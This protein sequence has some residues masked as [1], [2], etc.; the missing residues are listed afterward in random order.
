MVNVGS[1]KRQIRHKKLWLVRV[2]SHNDSN[3]KSNAKMKEFCHNIY[4]ICEW[5]KFNWCKMQHPQWYGRCD[6]QNFR[7]CRCTPSKQCSPTPDA[8]HYWGLVRGYK[9]WVTRRSKS[10]SRRSDKCWRLYTIL[11]FVIGLNTTP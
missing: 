1:D 3:N 2:V 10:D 11:E 8:K 4:H 6:F 7:V 5:E 9:W